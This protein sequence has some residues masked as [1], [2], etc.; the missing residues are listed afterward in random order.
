M[1]DVE[2]IKNQGQEIGKKVAVAGGVL[3]AG[4][5][6]KRAFTND[7]KKARKVTAEKKGD[8]DF[9]PGIAASHPIP[10]YDPIAH[11]PASEFVAQEP[12]TISGTG[13]KPKKVKA[14]K[15][16][17]E[18]GLVQK[19]IH[20][21]FARTMAL[22]GIAVLVAYITKKAAD[23]VQSQPENNDIAAKAV[24][25]TVADPVVQSASEKHAI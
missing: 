14:S 4:Y 7:K 1:G 22:E 10:D 15:K 2:Q 19:L 12:E 21:E 9:T 3:L 5:L 17:S 13:R 25:A 16:R 11:T 20:S 18:P 8:K 24:P 23:R 6:L